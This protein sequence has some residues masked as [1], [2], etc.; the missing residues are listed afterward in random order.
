MAEERTLGDAVEDLG[1][2]AELNH[3]FFQ[4][5]LALY[6][7]VSFSVVEGR[8]LLKGSV[9]THEDRIR[10][11]WVARQAT[12]ISEVINEMQVTA[13]SGILNYARDRWIS[14]QVDAKLLLD[15][16]ILSIN[17]DVET[18]NGTVYLLGIAQSEDELKRVEEHVSSIGGVKG[19]REPRGH[20]GRS[21]PTGATLMAAEMIERA[22]RAVG[23]LAD[24]EIDLADAAL[25][26]G[27]L[28]MP[29]VSLKRYPGSCRASGMETWQR[30]PGPA[31][32]WSAAAVTSTPY[33]TTRMA[34][35]AMPRPTMRPRMR[36]CCR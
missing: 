6:R 4:D 11:S 15:F 29:S 31:S 20:E 33:C 23:T 35:P 18:V 9:P 3:L 7:D 26:L 32:R 14:L 1:I 25:L 12:G 2:Q 21:A 13:E 10:A 16:D 19:R 5:D 27:A 30:S 8:V 36:T 22:L 34:T 17:Y 28:D 24:E